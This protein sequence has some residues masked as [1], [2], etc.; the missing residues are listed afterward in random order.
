MA[1]P[2]DKPHRQTVVVKGTPRRE[3][4]LPFRKAQGTTKSTPS[5]RGPTLP[6]RGGG[7]A[8]P[9]P[10]AQ[11]TPGAP[12]SPEALPNLAVP[13]G[14]RTKSATSGRPSIV[15]VHAA[16]SL[17]VVAFPWSL[18]D[19]CVLVVVAKCTGALSPDGTVALHEQARP[20]SKDV[21]TARALSGRS[22]E[23]ERS[24]RYA[25]DFAVCKRLAD[26]TAVGH[27]YAPGRSG[28]AARVAFRF[29]YPDEGA[30][31]LG[32][33]RHIAVFGDRNWTRG[34]LGVSQSAP[35]PFERMPLVYERAYGGPRSVDNPVGIGM[36][37]ERLPNLEHPE[38]L[39]QDPKRGAPVMGFGPIAKH[40]GP[41][42]PA[43][44]PHADFPSDYD[45]D[46]HQ[47]APVEQRLTRVR[48]DEPF[49]FVAMH[50][51][52]PQIEGRLPGCAAR[53]VITMRNAEQRPLSL[54]LDTVAF[55]LDALEVALVWRARV[56]IQHPRA[57]EIQSVTLGL[58][59]DART[60]A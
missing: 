52:H 60:Y 28:P 10:A 37:G 57:P 38:Q 55:D 29:G 51:E 3:S 43:L 27:A 34:V 50:S 20:L 5:S 8:S 1:D 19:G 21:F 9:L 46:R 13:M 24:L 35:E 30:D 42:A 33:T 11:P 23:Q 32:F 58:T 17:D 4:T 18:A 54:V 45:W 49:A 36:E 12:W 47:Q 6:F 39:M 48:G 7:A 14:A 16:P 40:W 53:G 2:P 26:V 59:Q 31:K 25:S 15:P 56:P 22:L 41:G 44:P